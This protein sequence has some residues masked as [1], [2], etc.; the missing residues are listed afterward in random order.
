MRQ[1]GG[2]RCSAAG[3]QPCSRSPARR[4]PLAAVAERQLGALA[5]ALAASPVGAISKPPRVAPKPNTGQEHRQEPRPHVAGT[6]SAARARDPNRREGHRGMHVQAPPPRGACHGAPCPSPPLAQ[7]SHGIDLGLVL[8]LQRRA[9]EL[10]GGGEQV[11]LHREVVLGA[12]H[13][14]G[15]DLLK[16]LRPRNGGGGRQAG[17]EAV[18]RGSPRGRPPACFNWVCANREAGQGS[19]AA[20]SSASP[21]PLAS[22]RSQG[23]RDAWCSQPAPARP[24]T[25]SLPSLA[26]AVSCASSAL[27]TWG[28]RRTSG[29]GREGWEAS[30]RGTPGLRRGGRAAALWRAL[31][32]CHWHT[33]F[34]LCAWLFGG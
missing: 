28:G 10:E 33:S 18:L 27:F 5:S 26:V 14:D 7:A 8:L 13:V 2:P 9:L 11:V 12:L 31:R 32:C 6:S 20:L 16:A 24:P 22:A 25:L 15:L 1:L 23:P 30:K 17:G 4:R 19:E 3:A 34:G 29:G 21:P